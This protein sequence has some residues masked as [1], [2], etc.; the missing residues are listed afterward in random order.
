MEH[1]STQRLKKKEGATST[2]LKPPTAVFS[3]CVLVNPT[4]PDK[5]VGLLS[6]GVEKLGI[7]NNMMQAKRGVNNLQKKPPVR[8]VVKLGCEEATPEYSDYNSH[9]KLVL[10]LQQPYSP[11]Q[12]V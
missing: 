1:T 9:S 8:F 12:L 4:I 7:S 11:K 10:W 6:V 2:Y 3:T 5:M